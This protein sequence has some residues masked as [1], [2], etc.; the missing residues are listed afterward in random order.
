MIKK[1]IIFQTF[2]L[3]FV[4]FFLPCAY[5]SPTIVVLG[6]SLSAAFRMSPEQNWVSLLDTRLK[7]KYPEGQVINSSVSGDTTA[8]GLLRIKA[9]LARKNPDILILELG[10]NDALRGLP[11][12]SIQTNLGKIIEICQEKHTALLLIEAP[13]PPNYGMAYS[14]KLKD[15]FQALS[16]KYEAPLVKGF[17]NGIGDQSEL[18]F[19]DGIHPKPEA[20]PALLEK[21]WPPLNT[22]LKQQ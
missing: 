13:I 6:D 20:Q 22:L 1:T 2:I 12:L 9:V 11:I 19:S 18:M 17:L 16:D 15:M 4:I 7:S 5:G 8:N 21:V 10:G 3:F 14:Q